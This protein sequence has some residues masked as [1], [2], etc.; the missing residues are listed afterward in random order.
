MRA[1]LGL[2][3]ARLRRRKRALAGIVLLS[4][5]ASTLVWKLDWGGLQ[6]E[7]RTEF[8]AGLVAFTQRPLQPGRPPTWR[9]ALRK[10]VAPL[11]HAPERSRDV[12][13]VTLDDKTLKAIAASLPLRQ[14]YGNWPYARTLWPEVND[15]LFALGARAVVLDFVFREPDAENPADDLSFADRLATSGQPV[16]LG[17]DT[18]EAEAPALPKVEPVNRLPALR[19]PVPRPPPADEEDP[20]AEKAAPFVLPPEE[21]ARALAVPVAL[22]GGAVVAPLRAG[23]R[24][25]HV[26]APLPEFLHGGPGFGLVRPEADPDGKMRRARL[27]YTDGQNTYP[28]LALAAVMDLWGAEKV[29]LS[30]GR[31]QVG[32]H[33]VHLNADGEGELPFLGRFQDRFALV[34]LVDVLQLDVA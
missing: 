6:D 7:E 2:L 9:R 10:L 17:V 25:E 22:E 15:R 14:R 1:L 18:T 29:V 33:T 26:L 28:S 16:F 27:L 21:V 31:L 23:R 4:V 20:F 8:D 32:T 24:D 19:L 3:A 12:V 13:V 30:P 11:Q 5:A 34:P